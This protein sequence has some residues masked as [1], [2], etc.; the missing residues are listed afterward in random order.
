M[1][2]AYLSAPIIVEGLR[3]D[4]FCRAVVAALE[5]KDINVFAPQFLEPASPEEVY[6]RDVEHVRLADFIVAEVSNPS[7]GVGME[8]MLAIDLV[9]PVLM[10]HQNDV[11]ALSRMVRGADGKALFKYEDVGEVTSVLKS[12]NLESLIVQR[13]PVCSSQ[14]AEVLENGVRCVR[15]QFSS[16]DAMV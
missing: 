9:K 11:D 14:V 10:F 2:L 1:V 7:L 5:S 12:R 13:C 6:R 3:K 16:H 15:C 4:D 8:I